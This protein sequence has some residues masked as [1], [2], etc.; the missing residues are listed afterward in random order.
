MVHGYPALPALHPRAIVRLLLEKHDHLRRM[1][2]WE[3][4]GH[5][6]MFGCL[7]LPPTRASAQFGLV[8]MDTAGY[9]NMC[10]HGTI[11]AVVAALESGYISEALS[12]K[13]FDVEVPAGSVNVRFCRKAGYGV[14]VTV[15]NVPAFVLDE[16]FV[17]E[18]K[19]RQIR[20]AIVYSG[21]MF[22]LVDARQIGLAVQPDNLQELTDLGVAIRTAIN[23]QKSFVHPNDPEISGVELVE[24]S[25]ELDGSIAHVRNVV[26]FGRGQVDRSPCGSGT[27]AKMALLYSRGELKKQT[28]FIAQSVVGTLFH[29]RIVG[30]KKVGGVDTIVPEVSGTAFITGIQ[31]FVADPADPLREGFLLSSRTLVMRKPEPIA[32]SAK[33]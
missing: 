8:F 27:C 6:D 4:R 25:E 29:S 31:Q 18:A 13:S 16:D 33:M 17:V 12:Q 1:L 22:A 32:Y 7:L 21:N 10:V 30:S 20:S 24:F 23:Q 5:Q 28:E 14:E 15:R 26:V 2:M 9:L 3:P 19:G 11:G